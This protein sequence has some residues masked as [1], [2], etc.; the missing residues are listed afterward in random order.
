MSNLRVDHNLCKPTLGKYY[1]CEECYQVL[2]AEQNSA[3]EFRRLNRSLP[4]TNMPNANEQAD[5]NAVAIRALQDQ[6]RNLVAQ[7]TVQNQNG[8][9]GGG[10]NGRGEDRHN[11]LPT[12]WTPPVSPPS[13]SGNFSE[14]T[15]EFLIKARQI[16]VSRGVPEELF[17]KHWIPTMLTGAALEWYEEQ[18]AFENFGQFSASLKEEFNA[19]ANDDVLLERLDYRLQKPGESAT[20]YVEAMQT[21]I[22]KLTDPLPVLTQIRLIRRN[23]CDELRVSLATAKFT[24]VRALLADAVL[25]EQAKF[26]RKDKQ[27]AERSNSDF[28]TNNCSNG[29]SVNTLECFKC[30]GPH[31]QDKC[32]RFNRS[33]STF[34][35]YRSHNFRTNAS[36]NPPQ[37]RP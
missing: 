35:N 37:A 2:V 36:A 20:N 21:I 8:A 26:S 29:R 7:L 28:A 31:Y 22:R 34:Q 23:L 13:F 14:N 25:L 5:P 6:V 11:A 27:A 4:Q 16:L 1:S 30:G 24:S 18:I 10:G 15:K 12:S 19:Y 33:G 32:D 9:N 3:R 17:I